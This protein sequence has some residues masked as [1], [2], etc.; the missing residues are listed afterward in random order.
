MKKLATKNTAMKIVTVIFLCMGVMFLSAFTQSPKPSYMT[1]FEMASL[2]EEILNN[3]RINANAL[4]LPSFSDLSDLQCR[5]IRKVLVLKI[6]SGFADNT[7]RPSEPMR[8]LEVVSYLQK[9]TEL[10]RKQN[11][12]SEQAKKLFRFLSYNE[13]HRFPFEYNST[14]FPDGLQ[15][16]SKLTS[17]DLFKE[18][19][20]VLTCKTGNYH[21]L[22]GQI[23]NSFNTKPITT[24]YVSVNQKAVKVD[25]NG[26]FKIE[27]RKSIKIA[28]V[29]A[30]ADGFHSAEL[31]KDLTFGNNITIRLRPENNSK[32]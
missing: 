23:I 3:A 12:E 4:S 9:L 15:N 21:T 17:K 27:L 29:F 2:M 18:L 31:R 16:P 13:D 26:R 10:I 20:D 14:A 30:A 28:D 8:N 7:F 6:M 24:A 1:R 32:I 11:P 22:Y 25:E 5:T 19:S